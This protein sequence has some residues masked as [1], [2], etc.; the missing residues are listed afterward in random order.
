LLIS[1]SRSNT[2]ELA[3]DRLQTRPDLQNQG[4]AMNQLELHF[5]EDWIDEAEQAQARADAYRDLGWAVCV[6]AAEAIRDTCLAFYQR[7]KARL[8]EVE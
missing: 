1:T 5:C 7:A 2:D 6:E 8:L 4:E 3:T